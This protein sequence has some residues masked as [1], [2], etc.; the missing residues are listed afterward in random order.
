MTLFDFTL[1]LTRE[2]WPDIWQT[3]KSG[4]YRVERE[5]RT[6]AG[7]TFPVAI[8]VNYLTEG[9]R[10]YLCVFAHDIAERRSQDAKIRHLS[11]FPES[12]PYPILE[13]DPEGRLLYANPAALAEAQRLG[14]TDLRLF[15][16]LEDD[17]LRLAASQA[18][19]SHFSRELFLADRVF[20]AKLTYLPEFGSLRVSISDLTTRKRV[21]EKL[22]LTQ[23]SIDHCAELVHW[24]DPAGQIVEVN[25]SSWR[26]YGYSREEMLGL[27]VFDLDP[28]LTRERW[29]ERWEEIKKRGSSTVETVHRTKEGELFPVEV[30]ANYVEHGGREY[31]VSFLREITERRNAQQALRQSEEQLRQAQKMEAVGQ[32]AGGIAHD[33]NNLLTAI[34][35]NSSL[36]LASLAPEDPNRELIA[37]VQEVGERAAALTRQIL[38]FSR[39]QVLR[40][41]ITC[42]N[43]VILDLE[44]L[45]GRTLGEDVVLE[46]SLA[47]D[48]RQS[49]ID[50][51]QIEQVLLNLALN[52][53]DAMP[54]GGRLLIETTNA[55]LDKA[56]CEKHPEV[57]AGDYVLL[58]VSDT[59]CG[60]EADT[61]GHIFEPFFTTKEVGKGTGLGLSTA[62]GIVKQSGGSISAYSEPGQGTTFKVY[63]PAVET[64]A[65]PAAEPAQGRD[66]C[67][68]GCECIL[69]L[70]DEPSVRELVV[71]VLS[72][73]G[74]RVL[75]AG[76]AQE[77]ET[78]LDSPHHQPELLLTDVVLPG[79]AN[80]RQ[81]AET[82][83]ERFTRLRV[84]FMSGYTRNVLLDDGRLGQG[85]AFLEK[86]FTPEALL[87][88][89]REVL[90][91]EVTSACKPVGAGSE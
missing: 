67:G 3:A 35:G 53:R 75:A 7:E 71:R 72:R 21:E 39:R 64:P 44:P 28:V 65:S 50:P 40:P 1:G 45:L 91:A 31:N 51:H 32:L 17:E 57:K 74:Y 2:A 26:R 37:D 88:A 6:K 60:M 12:N 62:F 24:V 41:E 61:L 46:F 70:E 30:T 42:L 29:P 36:A 14:V 83:S 80:G 20:E 77:V 8:G 78:V 34:I 47:S 9:G 63:L 13:F 76:S 58:A 85:F 68:R 48:L 87:G 5:L 84:L 82:L 25:E 15:L 22:L 33:F 81:V 89:V 19:E 4:S 52:A 59:G 73:S 79:G 86:P 56:Y 10:E 16:P 38:A 69:V 43:T 11:S 90:D 55:S 54:Q 23:F 66:D 27:A 49:E 18:R